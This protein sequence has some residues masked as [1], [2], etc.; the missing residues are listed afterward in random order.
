ML[1]N[2]PHMDD[3]VILHLHPIIEHLLPHDVA[4]LGGVGADDVQQFLDVN[5]LELVIVA[6]HV[7]LSHEGSDIGVALP[8]M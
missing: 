2:L 1:L 6:R 8:E 3:R 5:R 4:V 7:P